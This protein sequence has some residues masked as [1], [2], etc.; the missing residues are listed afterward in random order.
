MLVAFTDAARAVE[1][2]IAM[3]RAALFYSSANPQLPLTLS[4]GVASG[5]PLVGKHGLS[6]SPVPEA[7]RLC[8]KA[9]PGQILAAELVQS[10]CI[11]G[12]LKFREAADAGGVAPDGS[13]PFVEVDWRDDSGPAAPAPPPI[14][15]PPPP[16]VPPAAAR[17]T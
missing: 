6:G 9:A 10:Q 13:T 17:G 12:G 2:A 4:V 11:A 14:G 16:S 15:V 7:A 8:A 5:R 3:Q 1:A